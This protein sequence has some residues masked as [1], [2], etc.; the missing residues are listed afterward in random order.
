MNFQL[1]CILLTAPGSRNCYNQ[2]PKGIA[3]TYPSPVVTCRI[4]RPENESD[5]MSLPPET[6]FKRWLH[7]RLE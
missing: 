4:G 3:R 6:Q 5:L 7:S 1:Q 2:F